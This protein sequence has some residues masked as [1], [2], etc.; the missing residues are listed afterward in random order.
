[1]KLE[2]KAIGKAAIREE[3]GIP[4]PGLSYQANIS[5]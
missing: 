3:M 4:L 2:S 5:V 1:M